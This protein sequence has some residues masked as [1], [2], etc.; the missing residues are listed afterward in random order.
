MSPQPTQKLLKRRLPG[1]LAVLGIV[2]SLAAIGIVT[3]QVR[4]TLSLM[5]EQSAQASAQTLTRV[6]VS[7]SWDGIKE[8]TPP[9][10]SSGEV[11]RGNPNLPAID[12]IARRF[13]GSADVLRIKI[14]NLQGLIV[15]SSN[16]SD[17]GKDY[18]ASFGMQ[19]AL[20]GGIESEI[21]RARN[22]VSIDGSSRDRDVVSIYLPVRTPRG[23]EAVVELYFDRTDSVTR[24]DH[25]VNALMLWFLPV[26][27]L[28]TL[29]LLVVGYTL[30]QLERDAAA[31]L[32]RLADDSNQALA[33]ASQ[34]NTVKS[35]FLANMSHE[36]RTPMNGVLGMSELLLDSRLEPEQRELASQVHESAHSLLGLIDDILDLS[37]IESGKMIFEEYPLS[38]EQLMREVETLTRHTALRKGI[39]LQV[40]RAPNVS[41]YYK[42][43]STRL[44]QVLLNLVSNAIKFTP[45]GQVQLKVSRTPLG[46]HFDVIDTG[47]GM[48]AEE[49]SKLFRNFSQADA[50]T[51]RRFGGTGLGLVI[52]Q[53]L[54]Q[55]MGGQ[56]EARSEPG[57]GSWFS[58][59]LPLVVCDPPL[60][61]QEPERLVALTGQDAP[62][63]ARVLMAED[64]PVNQKL[65]GLLLERMGCRVTLAADGRQAVERARAERFDLILMDIQMPEMDGLEAARALRT[66]GGA[67]AGVPIIA[68]TANAMASDRA[69]CMAAGMNDFVAKPFKAADLRACMLRWLDP[70]PQTERSAQQ[71]SQSPRA[72]SPG[73][74]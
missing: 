62:L 55:G 47:I 38:I 44:R 45:R 10:N 5:L 14:F 22:F 9:P 25:Q 18:A 12:V 20:R 54:V 37:K 74:A 32:K 66:E 40:H 31:A 1:L 59:D 48:S 8:L 61:A 51:K 72:P 41:G 42:G 15:Y 19:S 34:A 11:I 4:A 13:A 3:T 63:D 56:I 28:M 49:L 7:E 27:L 35:Q 69:D 65:G 58:F 52:S 26:L 68:V 50:S 46:L 39:G 23:I 24:L 64:N 2:L 57:Q 53:A 60:R 71:A 43:D 67:S 29:V 30:R 21:T 70:Q 33:A 6:F 36:I 73:S 17:I 16:P